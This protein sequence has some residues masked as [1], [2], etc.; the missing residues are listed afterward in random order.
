MFIECH[1]RLEIYAYEKHLILMASIFAFK[2][3]LSNK[4]WNI[5]I[6]H[7]HAVSEAAIAAIAVIKSSDMSLIV[8][9][10]S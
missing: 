1:R 2:S 6:I 10:S 9:H 8:S 7:A 3:K 4:M 5:R